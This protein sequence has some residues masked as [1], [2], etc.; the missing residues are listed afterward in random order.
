M[1]RCLFLLSAIGALCMLNLVMVIFSL[2]SFSASVRC[3]IT[4]FIQK[5]CSLFWKSFGFGALFISVC[6]SFVPYLLAY[7]LCDCERAM[8]VLISATYAGD[9]VIEVVELYVF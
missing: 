7:W 3:A 8:C 1:E 5:S 9:I 2:M 4:V 6:V